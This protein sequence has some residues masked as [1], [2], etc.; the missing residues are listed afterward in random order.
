MFVKRI[1]AAVAVTA[2]TVIGVH[3]TADAAPAKSK[4]PVVSTNAIDWD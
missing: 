3:G 1:V 2:F 4:P